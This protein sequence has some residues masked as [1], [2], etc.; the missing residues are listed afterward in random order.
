LTFHTSFFFPYF[1]STAVR[2][3][4]PE[5]DFD[6]GQFALDVIE[7]VE[8]GMNGAEPFVLARSAWSFSVPNSHGEG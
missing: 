4:A 8:P 6:L 5:N 2:K 7:R 3:I 1:F